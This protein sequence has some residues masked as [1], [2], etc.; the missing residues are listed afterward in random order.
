V[1]VPQRDQSHAQQREERIERDRLEAESGPG[2]MLAVSR[3]V[4][5]I[6]VARR[7]LRH[8]MPRSEPSAS[9]SPRPRRRSGLSSR[10][11]GAETEAQIINP[12]GEPVNV[13]QI[14]RITVETYSRLVR[15]RSTP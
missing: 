6:S 13:R 11:V 3:Q 1:S 9:V 15:V 7:S 4:R 10:H 14:S 8:Q 5:K 2:P 12:K